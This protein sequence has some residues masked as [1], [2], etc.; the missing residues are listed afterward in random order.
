MRFCCRG[1][2]LV[3]NTPA[4]LNL[5]L[6]VLGRRPDGYHELETVMV[7]I[8]LYDTLLFTEDDSHQTRLRCHFAAPHGFSP[9]QRQSLTSDDNL[10]FRAANL[11]RE[12]TGCRRGVLIELTKRIP[13]Q[14][15]LGGGSSDAAAT[16]VGLNRFWHLGLSAGQLRDLAAL[17]GSDVNFF[18]DSPQ[19]AVCR[20]RGEKIAPLGLARRLHFVV[21]CPSSGLSTGA[22]FGH[23]QQ[24]PSQLP[25]TSSALVAALQGVATVRNDEVLFN[26]LQAP[27]SGLNA[28]VARTLADLRDAGADAVAMSGSGSSCFALCRSARH[29]RSLAGR[30]RGR[31]RSERRIFS[32]ST[33]A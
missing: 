20:G 33:G 8:R 12:Q 11:L 5:F 30:L 31:V 28:D 17:L 13:L 10:V 22:V 27:A 29:A 4:K 7:S 18:V 21:A 15:G 3:V 1:P 19:A 26:A 2:S 9:Q 25:R 6:E 32:L 16:L 14:A 23:W 24:Q